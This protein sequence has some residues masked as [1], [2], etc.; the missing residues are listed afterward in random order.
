[1]SVQSSLARLVSLANC[2]G[3]WLKSPS[4]KMGCLV[5]D[6]VYSMMSFMALMFWVRFAATEF[7]VEKP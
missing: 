6:L 3:S 4:M 1:M 2:C 7:E 5:R